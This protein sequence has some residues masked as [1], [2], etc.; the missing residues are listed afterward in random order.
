MGPIG[1]GKAQAALE[2]IYA[3]NNYLEKVLSNQGD[4]A[5][6]SE[7]SNNSALLSSSHV[8]MGG[9]GGA[10]ENSPSW[11]EPSELIGSSSWV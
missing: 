5:I 9:F 10:S 2:P 8:G 3:V 4:S 6:C 7:N 11:A 1:I